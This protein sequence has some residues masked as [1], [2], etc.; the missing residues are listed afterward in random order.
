MLLEFSLEVFGAIKFP[1]WLKPEAFSIGPL[2]VK[3]Y[4]ISYIVGLFGAYFYAKRSS[5]KQ[6]IWQNPQASGDPVLVPSKRNLEDLMFFSLLGII[7]GGRI[8]FILL[9]DLGA[10][11]ENPSRIFKV[12][13]GGMAF[14]GGFLGVC[15]AA[16]YLARSRGLKLIRVA[17]IL[18]ISAPIGIGL[19]RLANFVNQ[20]LYGRETDVPWAVIFMRD[21]YWLNPRHPSQL[22]EAFLEGLVIFSVLWLA[23]RKFKILTK[24]GLATG[25]FLMMYGSFRIFVEFFREPDAALFGPLTRGM[26]YS[27][28]MVL[29]GVLVILWASK[30]TPVL[31]KWP[32]AEEDDKADA[33]A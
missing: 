8:G 21:S 32:P 19:V 4:G 20:E 14:H 1:G 17:D 33:D 11:I 7:I 27:L 26:T 31:P 22:Y 5:A 12:W 15:V 18:A 6:S 2:S 9:Y 23:S 10:Y 25:M 29:I 24:P 30:R 13:E 3:W 28:P 16:I